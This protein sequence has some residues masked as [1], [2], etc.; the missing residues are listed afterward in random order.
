[1]K[2]QFSI[3]LIL[4]LYN[5]FGQQKIITDDIDHFWEA[6][7]KISHTKDSAAQYKYLDDL[8]ISRASAG[9][10]S[11][12]RVRRY[13]A[14]TYVDAINN[15]PLFWNSIRQNTF[16]SKALGK[17]ISAGIEKLKRIYPDLKPSTIYF[18]IGVF[19]TN[20]TV[21][22]N[23]VLIGSEMALSDKSVNTQELPEHPKEFN[24]LYTPI[25]EIELLCAHEYVHTQ[26]KPFV[27]NLLSYCL[28]EGI[29]EFVSTTALG[30]KSNTPAVA[31][32]KENS[33]KV[34]AKFEEDVF[35]PARTF[36][37]L[38]SENTIF[39]YR[40]LGYAVGFQIAEKYYSRAKNK[41][42]AI[43]DLIELDYGNEAQVE[44]LVDRSA[45]LSR[46]LSGIFEEFEKSRPFVTG[47]GPFE[48]GSTR[49]DPKT[50]TVTITF[51][52]PMDAN[53]RGFD[54][55]P[56]GEDNVLSVREVIGFSDDRKS[57]SYKVQLEPKKRYQ[58]LVT[59]R[60]TANG[61]PLKPYLI[62]ITTE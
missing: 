58:C 1:M 3:L 31:Y 13:T 53:S 34:R 30:K 38:W 59:N 60:F 17:E 19:R 8:Y 62:D 44:Q 32:G 29:A 36:N 26:Q 14:K 45:Y 23:K 28:Y 57:F 22:G 9:L 24:R 56:L 37:W 55:G 27:D 7:D 6:Y 35:I 54:Y 16:K 5:A 42:K 51:S 49:A 15:Y 46:P 20:G 4:L 25:N 33:A 41:K 11:L 61:I 39:G 2:H 47:V 50:T 48:N 40:D 52:Q 10:E 12:M 43:K 21:D 18:A